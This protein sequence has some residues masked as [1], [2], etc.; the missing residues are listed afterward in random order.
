M[1]FGLE[2]CLQRGQIP[3]VWDNKMNMIKKLDE[4]HCSSMYGQISKIRVHIR[5]LLINNDLPQLQE[6]V[7][8]CLWKQ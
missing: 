1:L 8:K 5:K 4:N 2:N 6:Y 7:C 3:F